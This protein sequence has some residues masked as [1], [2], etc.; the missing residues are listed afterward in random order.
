MTSN[1][2]YGERV[3]QKFSNRKIPNF[4]A[5]KRPFFTIFKYWLWAIFVHIFLFNPKILKPKKMESQKSA[6]LKKDKDDATITTRSISICCEI[7]CTPWK[8]Q[9]KIPLDVQQRLFFLK[10]SVVSWTYISTLPFSS[11]NS[12]SAY[13][14]PI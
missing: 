9:K 14:L 8:F 6:Y 4:F 5:K 1:R 3:Y 13:K 7:K 12:P 11:S 2:D 10:K